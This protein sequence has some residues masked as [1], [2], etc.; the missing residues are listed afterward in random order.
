MSKFIIHRA[1]FD[2]TEKIFEKE[3]NLRFHRFL[4]Q[5]ITALENDSS[6]NQILHLTPLLLLED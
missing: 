1:L 4:D 5:I 2:I 6:Y 3:L